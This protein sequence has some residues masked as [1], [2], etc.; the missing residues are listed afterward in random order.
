MAKVAS[1]SM[2]AANRRAVSS[3]PSRIRIRSALSTTYWLVAP[4]WMIPPGGRGGLFE[5]MDV[6]HHVV[7]KPFLP[8]G[9]FIEVD[10]VEVGGH[11]GQRCVGDAV[12]PQLLLAAPQFQPEPPPQAR[13]FSTP[14]TGKASPGWRCGW[15]GGRRRRRGMRSW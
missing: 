6:G 3:I 13:I 12:D 10:V 1:L 11:V 7:P 5:R 8:V 9:G 14:K 2:Q 4:R 15:R